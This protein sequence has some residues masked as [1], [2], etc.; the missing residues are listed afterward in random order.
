MESSGTSGGEIGPRSAGK[1]LDLIF[2]IY[3]KHILTLFGIALVVIVPMAAILVGLDQLALAEPDRLGDSLRVDVGGTT[4]LVDETNFYG[5]FVLQTL[6]AILGQLLIIGAAYRAASEAYLGREP[7]ARSSIGFG[8]RKMHSILWVTVLTGIA[9]ALGLLALF[10][11]AIY[12][13]IALIVAVP[14]LM[15]EDLRGTKALRRS[16]RLVQDNWWRTF[17][18]MVVATLFVVFA[19][20][21]LGILSFVANPLAEDSLLAYSVVIQAI[22]GLATALTAPL[23]AVA[24]I[25]VYYDLRIRKEGFDVELLADRMG[26][27]EAESN[28]APQ[29]APELPDRSSRPPPPPPPSGSRSA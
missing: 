3:F 19:G 11:G 6:I 13:Y 8:A 2:N 25:V 29:G 27:G 12:L 20:G 14:A 23:M 9:T 7:D 10:V 24:A 15:V 1:L 5:G 21:I 17:G 4:R 28:R 22:N 18:V 16:F 26:E